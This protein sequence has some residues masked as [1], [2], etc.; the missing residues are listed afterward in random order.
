MSNEFSRPTKTVK[1]TFESARRGHIGDMFTVIQWYDTNRY[2]YEVNEKTKKEFLTKIKD[3]IENNNPYFSEIKLK[4]YKGILSAKIK[5]DPKLNIFV[6]DN[7]YGKTTIIDAIIKSSTWI[8]NGIKNSS[9]GEGIEQDEINNSVDVY[10]SSINAT[11]NIGISDFNIILNKAKQGMPATNSSV[12]SEYKLLS[13]IYTDLNKEPLFGLPLFE[14]FSISRS[15][16]IEKEHCK[17]QN[18]NIQRVNKTDIY[19]NNDNKK[20]F[21]HL[22]EWLAYQQKKDNINNQVESSNISLLRKTLELN[23]QIYDQIPEEI[24]KT[25]IGKE[26]SIKI[27]NLKEEIDKEEI[28]NTTLTNIKILTKLLKEFMNISNI[29]IQ[30]TDD[31]IRVLLDKDGVTIDAYQ[32][33]QGEKAVFS[34]LTGIAY[35]L[36]I[37]NPQK[38]EKA[39]NGKG[40][41]IIDEIDLHLHPKWQQEIVLK[42]TKAFKNIQFILTTHSPQV[43]TTIDSHCIKKIKNTNGIIKINEPEFSLGSESKM[44]LEEIFNV[45]SRPENI[46]TVKELNEL[47]KLI[48]EDKWDTDR[49][50]EL[51]EKLNEWAGRNDPVIKKLE[52]DIKLRKRRMDMK[53]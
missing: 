16:D 8:T 40:V 3:E 7:G 44:V 18:I 11:L 42:L 39:L 51:I 43:L 23:S 49:A 19:N 13:K 41:V 35:Q 5:L 24:K 22:I 29:H 12:L 9:N 20:K 38:G 45:S 50:K 28:D 4:N 6:G 33:S 46:E 1:D 14:S 32:L 48:S 52:M 26:L 53:K 37:L 31:Q 17:K 30:A 25:D 27:R 34:L 21:K 47:Q 10:E 2:N 15:L 36:L